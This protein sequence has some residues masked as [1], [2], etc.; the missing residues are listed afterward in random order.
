ME[1][2]KASLKELKNVLVELQAKVI[3]VKS[4]PI[5]QKVSSNEINPLAEIERNELN[6]LR[7]MRDKTD[8]VISAIIRK[9]ENELK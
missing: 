6:S 9:L 8:I 1:N 4:R 7:Q 5:E 2:I 3:E